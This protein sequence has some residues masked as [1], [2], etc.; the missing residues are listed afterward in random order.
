MK[1]ILSRYIVALLVVLIGVTLAQP[2]F[3]VADPAT[4]VGPDAQ[5]DSLFGLD[6]FIVSSLIGVL[7]PFLVAFV[8][9]ATISAGFKKLLTAILAAISGVIT[10]GATDGGGAIISVSSL[11]AAALTIFAA[12]STYILGLRNSKTEAKLQAVGPSVGPKAA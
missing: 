8:T 1:T 12:A 9:D 5:T 7:I 3:A 2:A 4:P 11:K 6:P 10:V